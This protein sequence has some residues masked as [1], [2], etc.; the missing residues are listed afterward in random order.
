MA[1]NSAPAQQKTRKSISLHHASTL[2]SP[3]RQMILQH[4][5]WNQARPRGVSTDEAF[6]KHPVEQHQVLAQSSTKP[7]TTAA[8]VGAKIRNTLSAIVSAPFTSQLPTYR[9]PMPD[10]FPTHSASSSRPPD[11][12]S[13][14]SLPVYTEAGF[15]DEARNLP[16]PNYVQRYDG[17]EI[18]VV[19][20]KEKKTRWWSGKREQE[21]VI[22]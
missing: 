9:E 18:G 3:T 16:P 7:T 14:T 12:P 4:S 17:H 13:T 21:K 20:V 1:T 19:G 22:R 6:E 8:N 5:V 2:N 11:I 15:I 10:H